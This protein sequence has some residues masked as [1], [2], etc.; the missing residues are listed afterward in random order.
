MKVHSALAATLALVLTGC[1]EPQISKEWDANMNAQAEAE[2]A[3]AEQ[4]DAAPP[5]EA[6]PASY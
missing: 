2:A 1:E 6:E 5:T 4:S 3:N